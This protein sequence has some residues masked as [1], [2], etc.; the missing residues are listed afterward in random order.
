M[1]TEKHAVHNTEPAVQGLNK[2]SGFDRPRY[3]RKANGEYILDLPYKKLWFRLKYPNGKIKYT[4]V[5]MTADAAIVEA[6]TFFD[7][8]DNESV[9]IYS[10]GK[11]IVGWLR[12]PESCTK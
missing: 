9:S 5:R 2:V 11:Q 6:R 8:R 10:A 1:T 7:R 12:L 4:L 3:L